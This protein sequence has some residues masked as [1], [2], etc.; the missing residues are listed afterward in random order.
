MMSIKAWSNQ[1]ADKSVSA[2]QKRKSELL[3][4]KISMEARV[5]LILVVDSAFSKDRGRCSCI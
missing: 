5:V 2:W 3:P 1:S 4:S